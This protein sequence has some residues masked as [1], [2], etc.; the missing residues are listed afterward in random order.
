MVLRD[1]MQK[2]VFVKNKLWAIIGIL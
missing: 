1:D 2:S